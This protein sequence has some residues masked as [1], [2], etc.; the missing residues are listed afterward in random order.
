MRYTIDM[1][2]AELIG[3]IVEHLQTLEDED[4]QQM[5]EQLED[6]SED[7]TDANIQV[8]TYGVDDS[9]HINSSHKNA[10]DLEQALVHI[11]STHTIINT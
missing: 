5:L 10:R 3:Q 4:L 6:T 9:E 7:I 11:R 1:N 2:R 8:I